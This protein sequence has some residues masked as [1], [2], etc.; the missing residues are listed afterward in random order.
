[1]WPPSFAPASS[2]SL[3]TISLH[4]DKPSETIS[5]SAPRGSSAPLLPVPQGLHLASYSCRSDSG[6]AARR[7]PHI[8]QRQAALCPA[9]IPTH[10]GCPL[11]AKFRFK[12]AP[13]TSE[14]AIINCKRV[15]EKHVSQ[16][17]WYE[18][19]RE[20]N[21]NSPRGN[22]PHMIYLSICL[23]VSSALITS[24]KCISWA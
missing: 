3:E 9:G 22:A 15:L 24:V 6:P 11:P 17:K 19:L 2:S 23:S 20:D 21:V 10:S 1:M 14:N 12:S 7:S 16:W 4:R 8:H 13:W 5:L 18:K